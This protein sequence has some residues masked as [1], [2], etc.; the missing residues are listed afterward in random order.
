LAHRY[1]WEQHFGA[2]PEGYVVHHIDGDKANNSIDNLRCVDLNY[3]SRVLHKNDC[4]G[5]GI[6]TK[7]KQKPDC[8]VKRERLVGQTRLVHVR[9]SYEEHLRIKEQS[10]LTHREV[11]AIIREAIEQYYL[12]GAGK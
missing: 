7:N 4:K 2:I 5:R 10:N 12:R 1:A 6:G 11:S 8:F 3:H 9:M